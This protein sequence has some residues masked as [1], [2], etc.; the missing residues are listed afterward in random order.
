ME[1]ESQSKKEII[2]LHS[3]GFYSLNNFAGRSI[4]SQD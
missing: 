3:N 4:K 2:L 1:I